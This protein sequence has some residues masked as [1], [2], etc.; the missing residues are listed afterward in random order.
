MN[1]PQEE[2]LYEL[3]HVSEHFNIEKGSKKM[4]SDKQF[5]AYA[6]KMQIKE[7]ERNYKGLIKEKKSAPFN[8]EIIET[9]LGE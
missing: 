2:V 4:W 3:G 8:G 7:K 5:V 9:S 6:K 1:L